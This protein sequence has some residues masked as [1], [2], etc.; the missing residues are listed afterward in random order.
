MQIH[1]VS[2]A[3]VYYLV[4]GVIDAIN[5]TKGLAYRFPTH[6]EQKE[7][8][9]GFQARSG[10]GFSK[11]I[12][13]I[14]GLIICILKPCLKYSRKANCGQVNFRCHRKDKYGLNL[15]AICDHRLKFIWVEM[16]WPGAT[17]DFMAWA[18]SKLCRLLEDNALTK[19][20]LEGFTFVGDNAY[21]EKMY[22][23]T[24]LKGMRS[25][26]EDAYNFYLSQL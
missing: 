18:T 12:G 23:A 26:Y 16:K 22:M 3:S 7:I 9:R 5:T 2:L 15:Q 24:P 21:V 19:L 8:A 20:I 4:W 10:A 6:D 25:G 14:D 13:A 17:S 1:D 11:V